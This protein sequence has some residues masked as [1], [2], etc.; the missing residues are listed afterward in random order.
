[1]VESMAQRAFC[2]IAAF[3]VA[4]KDLARQAWERRKK[5]LCIGSAIGGS[6]MNLSVWYQGR[7]TSFYQPWDCGQEHT[8]H[9]A[10]N[11]SGKTG[12]R[13]KRFGTAGCHFDFLLLFFS[14]SN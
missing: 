9:Q 14:S 13:T 7:H 6:P 5:M 11:S 4:P 8:R 3:G 2:F 12:T 1:M 10:G